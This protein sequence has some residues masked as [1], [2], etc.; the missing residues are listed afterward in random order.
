M[1]ALVPNEISTALNASDSGLGSIFTN[2]QD[3]VQTVSSI[4][5]QIKGIADGLEGQSGSTS[6]PPVAVSA[7]PVSTPPVQTGA[8]ITPDAAVFSLS[9]NTMIIGAVALV[10]V[11]L[12][13]V[14]D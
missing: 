9:K 14:L 4:W 8:V 13:L 12:V 3:V 2:A 7:P 6:V 10:V 1:A 5:D 11:G